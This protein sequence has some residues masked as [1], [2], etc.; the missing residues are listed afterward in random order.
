MD[1]GSDEARCQAI[2]AHPVR[3]K[4][5]GEVLDQSHDGGLGGGIGVKAWEGGC[6]AAS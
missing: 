1:V 2:D 4:L 3:S 5:D 6:R